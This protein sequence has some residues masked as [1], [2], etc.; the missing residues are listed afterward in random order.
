M[1]NRTA[2][3]LSRQIARF[4]ARTPRVTY[5]AISAR[6]DIRKPNGEADPGMAKLLENGYEPKR[7]ATRARLGLAG[8][9][10][11]PRCHR[12]TRAAARR[13][14]RPMSEADRY[15]RALAPERRA[16]WKEFI[17]REEGR[18]R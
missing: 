16:Q 4:R 2:T 7:E 17:M 9:H 1:P 15:W 12:K 3:S 5:R 10:V 14:V 13:V 18:M 8:G 6:L 11:C